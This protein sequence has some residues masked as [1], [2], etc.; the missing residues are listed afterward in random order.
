VSVFSETE[1]NQLRHGQEYHTKPQSAA[2]NASYAN[3][4]SDRLEFIRD[5]V[6]RDEL[7]LEHSTRELLWTTATKGQKPDAIM[8]SNPA[9]HSSRNPSSL[10]TCI[11]S[12]RSSGKESV[13]LSVKLR[14][15]NTVAFMLS[16]LRVIKL[17]AKWMSKD[18]IVVFE[19]NDGDVARYLYQNLYGKDGSM[20][21]FG[22][23][24]ISP[25]N[26]SPL[27][28]PSSRLFAS[29]AIDNIGDTLHQLDR[30]LVFLEPHGSMPNLDLLNIFTQAAHH[31]GGRSGLDPASPSE[32]SN[33]NVRSF[34]LYLWNGAF[35]VPRTHAAH[36]SRV[37]LASL[38]LS[39][40]VPSEER[41][42]FVLNP[43]R[44][45]TGSSEEQQEYFLSQNGTEGQ[46]VSPFSSASPQSTS[47]P[48]PIQAVHFYAAGSIIEEALHHIQNTDETL[49]QSFEE[50]LLTSATEF[51]ENEQNICIVLLSLALLL[52][53]IGYFLH[54]PHMTYHL[55]RALP[56]FSAKLISAFLVY[57]FPHVMHSVWLGHVEPWSSTG[58]MIQMIVSLLSFTVWC[59][60][61]WTLHQYF[62][63]F[64]VSQIVFGLDGLFGEWILREGEE[65]FTH[66]TM[67]WDGRNVADCASSN[68]NVDSDQESKLPID[69][70]SVSKT[71]LATFYYLMCFSHFCVVRNATFAFF[72]LCIPMVHVDVRRQSRTAQSSHT[73]LPH[74]HLCQYAAV[75]MRLFLAQPFIFSS[76]FY[77]FYKIGVAST[78]FEVILNHIR[79]DSMLWKVLMVVQLP[80]L[81]M[82]LE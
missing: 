23:S 3:L 44:T 18:L 37:G 71:T 75:A 30:L 81:L 80:L 66:R 56:S 8:D 63:R 31:L 68:A 6:L 38:G 52:R 54:V 27:L 60:F 64:V 35:S 43:Y 2:A 79:F 15:K 57:W 33:G 17:K 62:L 47:P 4:L 49:H 14:N 41:L 78:I 36:M 24:E 45:A 58:S 32:E 51:I 77:A 7:G 25:S 10:I 55:L 61:V 50:Y 65:G 16:L 82:Q 40:N 29:I 74:K 13:L 42:Q 72:I 5:A 22:P 11:R 76:L 28:T 1:R 53:P 9:H 34:L 26:I 39:T 12:K 59:I 69:P 19:G 46:Q 70:K 67:Q 73:F 20:S 48:V 21:S